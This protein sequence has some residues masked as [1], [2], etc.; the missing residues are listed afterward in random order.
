MQVLLKEDVKGLGK[1]GEIKNVADG[2][3]RN[4]LLKQGKAVEAT[5]T[6]INA[7]KIHN[8]AVER[9]KQEDKAAAILKVKQIEQIKLTI[10]VKVGS[11]GKLFGAVNTHAISVALQRHGI[12]VDK[13]QIVLPA[14]I[15][16]LGRHTIT[17][18]VYQGIVAKIAITVVAES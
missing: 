7:V 8:E 2:Y 9:H 10:G 4:C 15:K 1:T 14:P 3:A 16:S 11:N 5:S 18:K 13:Q 17:I 12:D 6:T